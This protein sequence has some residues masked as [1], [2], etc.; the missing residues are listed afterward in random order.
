MANSNDNKWWENYAVR[1][2]V[3]TVVGAGIV[4][5]LNQHPSSPFSGCFALLPSIKD[6]TPKDFAIF[7]SIGFSLCYIASAPILTFHATREHLRILQ[8]KKHFFRWPLLLAISGFAIWL[9][10]NSVTSWFP[11][12]LLVAIIG[13]QFLLLLTVIFD[14]FKSIREFYSRLSSARA[15]NTPGVYQYVESYRHL[16]EHGNAFSILLMEITL[17]SIL[18][19]LPSREAA[20]PLLVIW[21]LPASLC[22]LLGTALEMLFAEAPSN[23]SR[24]VA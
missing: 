14:R 21:I 2:L 8:L 10:R 5:F 7:A 20:I 22:W 1:Y 17:A 3:G 19:K 23:Q 12:Y 16:R 24:P 9:L 15:V 6:A 11:R 13:S 4:A 18:F